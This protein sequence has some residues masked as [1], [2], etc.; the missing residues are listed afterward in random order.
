MGFYT[1]LAQSANRLIKQKGQTVTLY[2]DHALPYDRT[3]GKARVTEKQYTGK[4]V[5]LP[6]TTENQFGTMIEAGDM[7][8]LLSCSQ[9]N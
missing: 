5:I 1:N 6:I 2:V 3:T 9:D 8:L 4:G 7:R